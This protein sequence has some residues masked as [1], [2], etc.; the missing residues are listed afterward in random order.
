MALEDVAAVRS[1]TSTAFGAR[2]GLADDSRFPA[3]LFETRFAA[4]PE[5]C[6]VACADGDPSRIVGALIS[7]TRGTLGW[8]GPLAVHPESQRTGAGGQLVARC[9][10]SWRARR[11]RLMGLET[12]G[13]SGFHVRFYGKFGFRPAWTGVAFSKRLAAATGPLPQAV[14][15]DGTIPDLGYIY[16]GLDIRAEA[17]ATVSSGAGKVITTA[18]GVAILHLQPTFQDSGTGFVPFLAAATDESFRTLMTAVE[19]ISASEG[20]ESLLARVPGSAASTIAVLE[21]RG[22][23]AGQVMVRMKA[24]ERP[25]YDQ[26]ASYYIDNWL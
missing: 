22:F 9:L 11:V 23:R 10:E 18:D 14:Q 17:T 21:Q 16:P 25:D 12:F 6:F 5:G 15:I 13:H 26:G 20:L 24:G 3:L 8:F 7:V 4:D 1:V 19:H 2:S